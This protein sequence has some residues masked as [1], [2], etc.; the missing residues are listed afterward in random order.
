[1]NQ[2]S[3]LLEAI[4]G[5]FLVLSFCSVC[6]FSYY[7]VANWKEG[8]LFLRPA[9]SLWA[10]FLGDT[11]LRGNFWFARHMINAGHKSFEAYSSV[12]MLSVFISS[13]ALLCMIAVFS[14]MKWRMRS[15]I[16]SVMITVFFLI[17]TLTKII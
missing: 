13:W 8:Y 14:P 9:I 7:I 3:V 1:M 10:I 5:D 17:L 4:N 12:T 16:I 2:E 6:I 15:W 11:I